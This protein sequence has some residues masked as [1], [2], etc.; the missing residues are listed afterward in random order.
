MLEQSRLSLSAALPKGLLSG[1]VDASLE[2][3]DNSSLLSNGDVRV[4]PFAVLKLTPSPDLRHGP[5]ASDE[6]ER[7]IV[8]TISD[9]PINTS[10]TSSTKPAGENFLPFP[11]DLLQ[12]PDLFGLD[13]D[14]SGIT[15]NLPLSLGQY[16]DFASYSSLIGSENDTYNASLSVSLEP[17]SGTIGFHDTMS[18]T[19]ADIPHTGP[20]A[21]HSETPINVLSEASFLLNI[22]Q[23]HLASRLTVVPLGQKTPWSTLNVPAAIVTLGDMTILDA[24][25]INHARQANLY[26]LLACAAS[27]IGMTPSHQLSTPASADYWKQIATQSYNDAKDHL[28]LSLNQETDG[29]AKAKYKEQLMAIFA[30]MESAV[31][32]YVLLGPI[33]SIW[34]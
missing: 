15:S 30:M 19:R 18:K 3:I 16:P 33:A 22:F 17:T 5:L 25:D 4:G 1:S 23:N 28:R 6:A 26:S 29:P 20:S 2:E 34:I 7:P 32:H 11:D 8:A 14:L 31:R 10:S 12:W 27:Y 9:G 24:P 21:T 13:D